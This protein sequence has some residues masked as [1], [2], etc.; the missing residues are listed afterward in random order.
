MVSEKSLI[1]RGRLS[2]LTVRCPDCQQVW[3][4]PGLSNGDKYVCKNCG[5]AFVNTEPEDSRR[6]RDLPCPLTPPDRVETPA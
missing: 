4:A 6:P 5:A 3:L 2:R 1:F